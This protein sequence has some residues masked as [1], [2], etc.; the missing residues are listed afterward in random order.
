MIWLVPGFAHKTV[1]F[2]YVTSYVSRMFHH[3]Q[4]N[5]QKYLGLPEDEM[6]YQR[7]KENILT[8]KKL[9]HYFSRYARK[10]ERPRH[11]S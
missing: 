3:G 2:T 4:E 10:I 9:E 11:D 8:N 5:K 6:L 7:K 1:F